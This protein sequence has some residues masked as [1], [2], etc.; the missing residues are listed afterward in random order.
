MQRFYA[1]GIFGAIVALVGLWRVVFNLRYIGRTTLT[2]G[3]LAKWEITDAGKVGGPDSKDGRRSYRP[4]VAFRAADG[5]EHRATGSMYRQSYHAPASD[6]AAFAV[7]YVPSN[8]ADARVV[9]FTDFWL[10]PLGLL[11]VGIVCLVI[12]ANSYEG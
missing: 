10:F 3:K 4:I 1:F 6:G 7:R 8:P 2:E 9:T 12:A 5:S 11:G